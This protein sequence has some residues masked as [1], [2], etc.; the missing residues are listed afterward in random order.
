MKTTQAIVDSAARYRDG[1][2]VTCSA[3]VKWAWERH[4]VLISVERAADIWRRAS[5]REGAEWVALHHDVAIA[6]RQ[7]SSAVDSYFAPWIDAESRRQVAV[8][9]LLKPCVRMVRLVGVA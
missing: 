5:A 8:R 3:L 2:H 7:M 4:R 9:D 6:S 1:E